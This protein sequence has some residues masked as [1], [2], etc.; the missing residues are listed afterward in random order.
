MFVGFVCISH[1]AHLL[2]RTSLDLRL[3]LGLCLFLIFYYSLL[4]LPWFFVT[5]RILLC[6]YIFTNLKK[7]PSSSNSGLVLSF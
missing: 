2:L 5:G 4:G 6:I 3:G 1:V 7:T